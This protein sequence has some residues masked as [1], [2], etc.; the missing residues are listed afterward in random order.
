MTPSEGE[1]RNK[2]K[3]MAN[4]PGVFSSFSAIMRKGGGAGGRTKLVS[5]STRYTY[6]LSIM[7][8][9]VPGIDQMR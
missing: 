1:Q 2:E 5:A 3:F 8:I 4:T 9:V 6:F 7:Y